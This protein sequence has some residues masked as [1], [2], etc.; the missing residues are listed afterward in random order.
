MCPKHFCL[1]YQSNPWRKGSLNYPY[2]QLGNGF[3]QPAPGNLQGWWSS[4]VWWL[5][6]GCTKPLG[7]KFF[8]LFNPSVPR[9][10]FV[11]CSLLHHMVPMETVWLWLLPALQVLQVTFRRAL[12]LL[13]T[14]LNKLSSFHLPTVT[15]IPGMSKCPLCWQWMTVKLEKI[16]QIP[17]ESLSHPFAVICLRS[18]IKKD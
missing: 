15:A 11:Y 3:V 12:S 16:K 2:R 5:V 18:R 7:K 4:S 1:M 14:I 9:Y 8:L 6:Q 10:D 13:F 17:L